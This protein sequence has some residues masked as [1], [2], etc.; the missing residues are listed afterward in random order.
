M[1]DTHPTPSG[2]ASPVQE[3]DANPDTS[4]NTCNVLDVQR[5][6]KPVGL[7]EQSRE[8]SCRR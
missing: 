3:T 1:R 5:T 4:N 6:G 2:S 7:T 8:A